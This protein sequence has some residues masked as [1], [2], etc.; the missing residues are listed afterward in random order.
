MRVSKGTPEATFTC[1]SDRAR[2]PFL[3]MQVGREGRY[4]RGSAAIWRRLLRATCVLILTANIVAF[5]GVRFDQASAATERPFAYAQ[6]RRPGRERIELVRVPYRSTP[7]SPVRATFLRRRYPERS[8]VVSA[9]SI[10]P[11]GIRSRR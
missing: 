11:A 5:I 4:V 7:S 1:H 2:I 3:Q 8:E 6:D 10:P 9:P